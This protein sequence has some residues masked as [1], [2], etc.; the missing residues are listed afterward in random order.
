MFWDALDARQIPEETLADNTLAEGDPL[1]RGS[2]SRDPP[3]LITE[4]DAPC[5]GG[6]DEGSRGEQAKSLKRGAEGLDEQTPKRPCVA[7]ASSAGE[8]SFAALRS[9]FLSLPLDERLQFLSWL[10]EGA[11]ASCTPESNES[12]RSAVRKDSR[13]ET[14]QTRPERGEGRKGQKRWSAEEDARLRGMMEERRSW[15]EIEKCFPGRT[16][17]ALRQRQSTLRGNRRKIRPA[18]PT[19]AT[20][21]VAVVI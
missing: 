15:S 19:P 20:P 21:A 14:E 3:R 12:A 9:H 2:Q 6:V 1:I 7:S 13:Q 17:S 18:R 10:F 16:E 8:G 4:T 11:L 5:S